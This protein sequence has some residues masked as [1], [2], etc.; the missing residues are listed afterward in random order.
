MVSFN[1]YG[2]V[3][4]QK[5]KSYDFGLNYCVNRIAYRLTPGNMAVLDYDEIRL[6]KDREQ[7]KADNLDA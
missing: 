6:L 5:A 3:E 7:K 1:W 2:A 4:A